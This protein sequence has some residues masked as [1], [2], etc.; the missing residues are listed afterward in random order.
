M[1]RS[2]LLYTALVFGAN[3]AFAADPDWQAARDGGLDKLVVAE[4]PAPV[5]AAEFTDRDGGTHTLADWQGKVVLLNFWATWCA[6]CREE[7]PALD[8]LQAE[9]GGDDFEV[10]TIATGRNAVERIDE[11]SLAHPKVAITKRVEEHWRYRNEPF[12]RTVEEERDDELFTS[13]VCVAGE[14]PWNATK[15]ADSD[16][17]GCARGR[18]HDGPRPVGSGAVRDV[19]RVKGSNLRRLSRQIYSLLP[20]TTRAT[21]P[22]H[23]LAGAPETIA[24]SAAWLTRR[25]TS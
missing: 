20:L 10:V 24:R 22:R 5:A 7:M 17:D 4:E 14:H 16:A 19:W 23:T 21:R 8:R 15:Q 2:A 13:R 12:D 9:L 6:P 11:V 18:T 1:L 3:T 25:S